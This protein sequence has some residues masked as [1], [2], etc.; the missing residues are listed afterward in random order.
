MVRRTLPLA[1]QAAQEIFKGIE[2]GKL[3]RANGVLPSE[4]ELSQKFA[5]SRATIRDALAQLEQRG[6][7]TRRHGAGTFV[8]P[9]PRLDAG[10]EELVSLETLARRIGLETRMNQPH[11]EAR[12]ATTTE[13]ERLQASSGTRVLSIARVILTGARPIAYLVDVVPTTILQPQDLDK[14]FRGSVLDLFLPRR[15]LALS[16][17]RTEI[18]IASA[19]ADIARKLRLKRGAPLHKLVAQ[20]FARD[21]RVVDYS[22]SYFVPGYFSFH[23]IRRVGNGS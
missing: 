16:H 19:N 14:N 10:L 12:A 5:V 9:Q 8:N 3:V 23:V 6:V 21:G 13:A 2:S 4:A 15:D 18:S 11:I 7:I 1:R 20:L 22:I 17:S